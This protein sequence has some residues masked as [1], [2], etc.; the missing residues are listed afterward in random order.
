MKE[1]KNFPFVKL[2][3]AR[4]WKKKGEEVVVVDGMRI[5]CLRNTFSIPPCNLAGEKE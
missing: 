4:E 2:L 3:G 1:K 5:V